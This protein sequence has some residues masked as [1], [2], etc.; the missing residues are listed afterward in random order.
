MCLRRY[1]FTQSRRSRRWCLLRNN[2][3][4]SNVPAGS[5][6][7]SPTNRRL[8]LSTYVRRGVDCCVSREPTDRPGAFQLRAAINYNFISFILLLYVFL[9]FIIFFFFWQTF[10]ST[11][12]AERPQCPHPILNLHTKHIIVISI[13]IFILFRIIICL[14]SWR[15]VYLYSS[16]SGAVFS[17]SSQF[18]TLC[19]IM[20]CPCMTQVCSSL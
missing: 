14:G 13:C 2:D 3:T 15:F 8:L 17:S 5:T 10:S 12:K 1:M 9:F 4:I 7:P 20:W 16:R 19:R 18:N 11:L 6:N